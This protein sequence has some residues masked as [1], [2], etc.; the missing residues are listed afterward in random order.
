LPS[1]QWR[2]MC[3]L[4]LSLSLSLTSGNTIG[5]R[6]CAFFLTQRTLPDAPREFHLSLSLSLSP[7]LSRRKK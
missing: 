6:K 4:A 5:W 1:Q 3:T 2:K 7:P